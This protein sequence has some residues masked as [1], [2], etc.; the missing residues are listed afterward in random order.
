M[1]H[2]PIASWPTPLPGLRTSMA[3]DLR[4]SWLSFSSSSTSMSVASVEVEFVDS[5]GDGSTVAGYGDGG[6]CKEAESDVPE[7]LGQGAL[8]LGDE[9]ISLGF[10]LQLTSACRD[11][12][13]STARVMM[14]S[15]YT[16]RRQN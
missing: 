3:G 9:S 14:A 13:E 4:S 11:R 12:R 7:S 1:A 2:T 15:L 5:T 16:E 8:E 6:G 10:W